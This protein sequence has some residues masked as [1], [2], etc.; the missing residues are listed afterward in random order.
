ML[1][2]SLE[3]DKILTFYSTLLGIILCVNKYLSP[4]SPQLN[5]R[6]ILLFIH[7]IPLSNSAQTY[8][9]VTQFYI[10]IIAFWVG[11]IVIF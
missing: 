11:Y 10:V 7:I 1:N 8:N 5:K 2:K 9:R 6:I 4:L 3:V